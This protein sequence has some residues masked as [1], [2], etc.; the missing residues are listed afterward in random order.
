MGVLGS[1]SI[2]VA[3]GNSLSLAPAA[4]ASTPPT[5]SRPR[6]SLFS[7]C[8]GCWVVRRSLRPMDIFWP[9]N[10][11]DYM[12]FLHTWLPRGGRVGRVL[13]AVVA[14]TAKAEGVAIG[15][16]TP[17]PTRTPHRS[18]SRDEASACSLRGTLP[19]RGRRSER[20]E[21]RV[22]LFLLSAR[23]CSCNP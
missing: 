17:K 2:A 4:R 15:R 1:V 18:N 9:R 16:T 5:Q 23:K 6:G 21:R 14:D 3:E 10:F 8:R 7:Y 20:S 19:I 12:D 22:A 13:P 11:P